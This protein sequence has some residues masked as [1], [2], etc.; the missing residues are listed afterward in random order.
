MIVTGVLARRAALGLTSEARCFVAVV[1]EVVTLRCQRAFGVVTEGRELVAHTAR[2]RVM[3]VVRAGVVV[4]RVSVRRHAC[5]AHDTHR[6]AVREHGFALRLDLVVPRRVALADR[7]G[8]GI[9]V[10]ARRDDPSTRTVA[11]VMVV[12]V[13]ARGRRERDAEPER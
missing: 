11:V 8:A 2:R 12:I 9:E 4:V 3:I 7:A 6:E 13:A 1:A 5:V 10:V